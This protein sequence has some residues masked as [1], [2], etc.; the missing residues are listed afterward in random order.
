MS[1]S[2]CSPGA[3]PGVP[4]SAQWQAAAPRARARCCASP[5]TRPARGR[6]Q[7]LCRR[8]GVDAATHLATGWNPCSTQHTQI[9][10]SNALATWGSTQHCWPAQTLVKHASGARLRLAMPPSRTSTRWLVMSCRWRVTEPSLSRMTCSNR[11]GCGSVSQRQ[12]GRRLRDV[13]TSATTGLA[14]SAGPAWAILQRMTMHQ[15]LAPSKKG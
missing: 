11:Q 3:A 7:V 14:A 2:R 1:C 8:V 4:G 5:G 15:Q 10:A 9:A 12:E 6:Q 13:G